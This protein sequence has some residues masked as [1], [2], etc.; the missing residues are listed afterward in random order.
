L[1]RDNFKFLYIDDVHTSQETFLRALG[2]YY[3]DRFASL[4]VNIIHTSQERQA[5]TACYGDSFAFLYVNIV[6][7]SQETQASTGCYEITL[8]FNL[9]YPILPIDTQFQFDSIYSQ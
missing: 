7:T 8:F 1:L 6:H 5:S 2:A 4:Y 3:G 9:V